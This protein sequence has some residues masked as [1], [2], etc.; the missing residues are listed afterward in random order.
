VSS[1]DR[2]TA[3]LLMP[4]RDCKT[5]AV[6]NLKRDLAEQF[7]IR[8]VTDQIDP[9]SATTARANELIAITMSEP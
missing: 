3:H 6:P 2:V 4:W 8:R 7:G 1:R 9:P 5:S